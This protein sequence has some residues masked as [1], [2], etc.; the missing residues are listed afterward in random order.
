MKIT[1]VGFDEQL[2]SS[3]LC[4]G[5]LVSIGIGLWNGGCLLENELFPLSVWNPFRCVISVRKKEKNTEST[6]IDGNQS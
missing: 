6:T 1:G 3:E 4:K 2:S 5:D